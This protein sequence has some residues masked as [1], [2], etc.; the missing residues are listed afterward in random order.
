M[1]VFRHDG[2]RR[3]GDICREQLVATALAH[4]VEIVVAVLLQDVLKGTRGGARFRF[5]FEDLCE[6]KT[7]AIGNI[8]SSQL[9][10]IGS[11]IL[12]IGIGK[13]AD[14]LGAMDSMACR[15]TTACRDKWGEQWNSNRVHRAEHVGSYMTRGL[16]RRLPLRH[17]SHKR[18]ERSQTNGVSGKR[19]TRPVK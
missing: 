8:D 19:E 9:A 14:L 18:K 16:R 12:F 17:V 13:F 10:H 4:W 11:P 5:L 15:E 1:S 2:C 6:F 3:A 7:I